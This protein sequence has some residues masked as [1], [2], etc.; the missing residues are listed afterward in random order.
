VRIDAARSSG[1][2]AVST[3][4]DDG[5]VLRVSQVIERVAS[6]GT[7]ADDD[8][9]HTREGA[10][11]RCDVAFGRQTIARWPVCSAGSGCRPWRAAARRPAAGGLV[12][13]M[14]NSKRALRAQD[15][16]LERIGRRRHWAATIRAGTRS[17]IRPPAG[18][19]TPTRVLGSVADRDP[20]A[21]QPDPSGREG[22]NLIPI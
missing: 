17:P 18:S 22:L 19:P 20:A 7:G 2:N 15:L 16:C 1:R 9:R 10:G 8:G 11:K 13:G 4:H 14:V 3:Q 5:V 6:D 12:E 21:N